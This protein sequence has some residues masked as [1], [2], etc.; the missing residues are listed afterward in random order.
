MDKKKIRITDRVV[1]TQGQYEGKHGYV[2]DEYV[3]LG[4]YAVVFDVT[5]FKNIF[6]GWSV[7]FIPKEYVRKE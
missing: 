5:W 3:N 6:L 7:V 4:Q 1:V 2:K